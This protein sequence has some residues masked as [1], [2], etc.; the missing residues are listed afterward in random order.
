MLS[1]GRYH[2]YVMLS[3]REYHVIDWSDT[4]LSTG[5]IPCYRLE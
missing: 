2:I 4:M 1:T 3:T 5:V